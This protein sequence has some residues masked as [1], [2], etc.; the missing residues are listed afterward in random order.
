MPPFQL[1]LRVRGDDVD[2]HGHVSPARLL[3][4]MEHARW[5]ALS[6]PLMEFGALM[7][8][9]NKLVVRAQRASFDHPAS[10]GDELAIAV[11]YRRVGN[12]SVEVGHT[13][14][15]AGGELVAAAIVTAVHLD[16]QGRP[17]PVPATLRSHTSDR[18][19]PPR[20]IAAT[21][22][23]T[24]VP[25][26]AFTYH[27]TIR[28][29]EIDVFEHVNH[30]R[31]VDMLDDARWYGEAAQAFGADWPAG[32]QL[33]RIALDYRNETRLGQTVGIHLWP[34]P[35]AA[36]IADERGLGC[37]MSEANADQPRCRAALWVRRPPA[38]AGF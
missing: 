30:A 25:L 31:Y 9:G 6:D 24:E 14:T 19:L 37:E 38:P 1:T 2:R 23:E 16:P 7:A 29:C 36:E 33:A 4:Y 18:P 3:A 5:E 13:V 28:P 27:H 12:T 35:E 11:W 34:L 26:A 20:L 10:Y 21:P 8:D 15:A 17:T 22:P 32:Q